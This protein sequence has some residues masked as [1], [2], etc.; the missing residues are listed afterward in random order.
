MRGT[1]QCPIPAACALGIIPAY[2]GNT[3]Q[4]IPRADGRRDHPRVCGEHLT[5]PEQKK[6]PW[7]SS[8]R[9]RGT[10]ERAADL[11][12]EGG[13][14]PA[15]AGNTDVHF[16]LH[17]LCGDH[18]RVCGEHDTLPEDPARRRG[19]SPRMRGTPGLHAIRRKHMG[20][21]PAYAGNT[22]LNID[23]MVINSGSSPRMR[24]TH[25]NGRP[26]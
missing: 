6:R 11:R 14:I 3:R 23:M 2:A 4:G 5:A 22:M 1:P 18:P 9:M 21:I 24:G 19:S 26:I 25:T 15:Y 17:L 16:V 20:I 8:P 12:D 13:I 7:G 10:P